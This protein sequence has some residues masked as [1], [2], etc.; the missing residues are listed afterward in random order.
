MGEMITNTFEK[1][2]V[3]FIQSGTCMTSSCLPRKQ[4]T[5]SIINDMFVNITR[6]TIISVFFSIGISYT[7]SISAVHTSLLKAL[8]QSFVITDI[9]DINEESRTFRL[10]SHNAVNVSV[11][12]SD[13]FCKF[14]YPSLIQFEQ[15]PIYSQYNVDKYLTCPHIKFHLNQTIINDTTEDLYI[16]EDNI[17]FNVNDYKI[18][19][20]FAIICLKDFIKNSSLDKIIP[21]G[22]YLL[23]ALG[24]FAFACSVISLACLFMTFITYCIFPSL[25]TIPGKNI[26]T[27][28]IFLF[29]SQ[30]FLQFGINLPNETKLCIAVG[31]CNHFC[32]LAS[33]CVMNVCSFHMFKLFCV[34]NFTRSVAS[35]QQQRSL[36]LKYLSYIVC[37][38]LILVLVT[39]S[40]NL[41]RY[42]NIGYGR[43]YCFISGF[44]IFIGTFLTPACLIFVS[45]II[46]F[47]IAF[48]KIRS[49]PTVQSTQNRNNF[50][51]CLRL[52]TIVGMTWPLIIVDNVVN[53]YW[54]SFFVYALNALQGCFIFFSFIVNKRV[55]S[56]FFSSVRNMYMNHS[57]NTERSGTD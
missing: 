5:H 12:L 45:N 43:H 57:A 53:L 10:Y 24:S 34:N 1:T 26:M 27:L 22:P 3:H 48:H 31:M 19:G 13:N 18:K 29:C 47:S 52:C 20:N 33:F 42:E 49:S 30:C 21:N 28:C 16:K 37:L 15:D 8:N 17:T 50:F 7:K 56:L 11:V 32:W 39:V 38:P 4:T 25:R 36:F 40:V 51:V 55:Y 14:I 9:P 35:I 44:Y 54:F 23:S 6:T 2:T 41:A 46:F